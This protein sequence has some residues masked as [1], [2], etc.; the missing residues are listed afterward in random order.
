[1]DKLIKLWLNLDEYWISYIH[2]KIGLVRGEYQTLGE[3]GI[4]YGKEIL[5]VERELCQL[6]CIHILPFL[7]NI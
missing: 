2:R 3:F 7:L 1:M 6:N 4:A 5:T